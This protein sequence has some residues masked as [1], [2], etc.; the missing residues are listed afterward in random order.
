MQ[1]SVRTGGKGT[2]R[3]KKKVVHKTG[4][5]DDKKLGASLKRL[6]VYHAYRNVVAHCG[7]RGVE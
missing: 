5:G 1:A 7:R 4:G 6:Q 3:R 2:M